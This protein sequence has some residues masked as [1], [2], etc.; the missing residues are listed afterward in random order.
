VGNKI[1][2]APHL[3]CSQNM[4]LINRELILSLIPLIIT[5][6]LKYGLPSIRLMFFSVLSALLIESFIS[7]FKK[8]PLTI[9]DGTAIFTGLLIAFSL[10]VAVAFGIVFLTNLIAVG[11]VKNIF[12]GRNGCIFN[13]VAVA[14]LFMCLAFPLPMKAPIMV[15]CLFFAVILGACWLFYK[16]IIDWK[17]PVSILIAVV[18]TSFIS[19]QKVHFLLAD[20]GLFFAVVYLFT[21]YTS[22]PYTK[23][24]RIIYGFTAGFL[25]VIVRNL[26]GMNAS[27]FLVVVITNS[28]VPIFERIGVYL[29]LYVHKKIFS[30]I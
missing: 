30:S 2:N 8:Q 27:I 4:L 13:Q 10:P 26:T 18:L 28:L 25:I 24:G 7:I 14:W 19:G 15:G 20:A 5:A 23:I 6:L 29:H 9:F 3:R 1:F 16:K 21:E 17:V 12:G 22:S 11:F